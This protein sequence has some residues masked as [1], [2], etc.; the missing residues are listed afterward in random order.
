MHGR[1]QARLALAGT[2]LLPS[3]SAERGRRQASMGRAILQTV[4][5]AGVLG[6]AVL[7]QAVLR[8]AVLLQGVLGQAVLGRSVRGPPAQRQAMR[9]VC[10]LLLPQ[11]LRAQAAVGHP[12]LTVAMDRRF[13]AVSA[14]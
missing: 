6:Q 11:V 12:G 1:L 3:G 13:C 10:A 8:A 14:L 5:L 9:S 2:R 7:G 4:L